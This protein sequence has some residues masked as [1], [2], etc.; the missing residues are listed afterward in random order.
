VLLSDIIVGEL[1]A[2][3]HPATF[4]RHFYQVGYVHMYRCGE[5]AYDEHWGI[6]LLL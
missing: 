1:S 4:T 6:T 5:Q 2:N 3:A